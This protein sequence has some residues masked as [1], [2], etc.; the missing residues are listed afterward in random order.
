MESEYFYVY[1]LRNE[2]NGWWYVGYTENIKQRVQAHIKGKVKST[3]NKRP[4]KLVF[5]E[6]YLSKVD[7]KRRE[8][9]LK[10][11]KG[12]TT[13]RTMLEDYLAKC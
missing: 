9:Y 11:T 4:L 6:A 3:R 2:T 12:K 1:V 7:A 8:H 13:L 10:T 5:C